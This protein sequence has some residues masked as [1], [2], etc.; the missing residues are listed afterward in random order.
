MVAGVIATAVTAA[1]PDGATVLDPNLNTGDAPFPTISPDGKWIAYV[2]QGFV[3]VCNVDEPHPRQVTEVPNSYT[4]PHLKAPAGHSPPTG[5]F[6]ELIRGLSHEEYLEL[7]SQITNSISGLFWLRDSTGFVFAAQTYDPT[8]KT[9]SYAVSLA[10]TDG[11]VKTLAQVPADSPTRP[12][13]A[14]IFARDRK[15]LVSAD[16][17]IAYPNHRPLIWD[18]QYDKPRATPFCALVPSA[19]SGRW[20]GIEKDTQQLVMTDENFEVTKRFDIHWSDK[21][22]RSFGLKLDLSPDERYVLWRNQIGFDYFSNW[23]GFRLDLQ[24]GIKRELSGHF[25]S[26][27]L[28]FTGRG[29]EFYR[30]GNDGVRSKHVTADE[31]TGAHLTIVPDGDAADVD[32]WRLKTN[33]VNT[34]S[35]AMAIYEPTTDLFAIALPR[36]A[37]K[38]PGLT[39]HLMDRSGKSWRMLGAES[40]YMLPF[41]VIGFVEQGRLIAARD[42]STLF[43]VSVDSIKRQD[44]ARK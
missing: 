2:R 30:C 39:W 32:V 4:W 25:M 21:S 9:L 5:S 28:E 16:Y 22:D 35:G 27:Q 43:T 24:T 10:L 23:E 12:V 15:Y 38:P 31:I 36:T 41:E 7:H 29:G 3:C 11:T 34:V 42:D 19:T 17:A 33:Q 44:D 6:D 20:I 26:E 8:L 18:V 40:A 13:G 1:V 14:G 37:D